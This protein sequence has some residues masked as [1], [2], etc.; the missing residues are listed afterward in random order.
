M[1]FLPTYS[2]RQRVNEI[3]PKANTSKQPWCDT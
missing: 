2:T 1:M 3:A